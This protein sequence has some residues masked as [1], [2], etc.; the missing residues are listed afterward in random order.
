MRIDAHQHFW[1][2]DR[3]DY[4]WLAD[5]PDILCKDFLP[6]DI[7]QFLQASKISATVLVQAAPTIEET[8]FLLE[9]ADQYA[10][11]KAVVGWIDFDA[12]AP[13]EDMKTL[14][15]NPKFKG[16]RPMIQDI[17]DVDWILKA[18]FDHIF[19]AMV[20]LGLTFDALVHPQHL[21]VLYKRLAQHPNLKVVIDHG[22][23][24]NIGK[25]LFGS[26]ADHI[27]RLADDT[28]CY[29]KISGLWT[30]AD[31]D[32]QIST[33]KRYTDHLLS[34]FGPERLMWGSDW[35]VLNLAGDYQSWFDQANEL[36]SCLSQEEINGIFGENARQF[37]GIDP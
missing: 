35:P 22:A 31:G 21:D 30:E 14:A 17:P 6:T 12:D 8:N 32:I 24:P 26:W 29:C 15:V 20:E 5:A 4:G 27:Q 13:V 1:K 37:Y 11:I 28:E 2:M 34:C 7:L 33:I 25:G 10:F 9:L 16:L 3:G 36:F 19:D 18:R 23:K